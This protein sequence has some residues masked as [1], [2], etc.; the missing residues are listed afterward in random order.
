MAAPLEDLF[1]LYSE[2]GPSGFQPYV[3]RLGEN[4]ARLGTEATAIVFVV[5]LR[6]GGAMLA[7]PMNS[8]PQSVLETGMDADFTV[9]LGPSL[10]VEVTAAHFMEDSPLMDPP[11]IP[12]ETLQVLLADF[13]GSIGDH[14]SE[15]T[16]FFEMDD[17][18]PFRPGDSLVIPSPDDL[19]A[20]AHSW[21]LAK[22]DLPERLVFYSAAEEE[23]VPETPRGGLPPKGRKATTSPKEGVADK[24]KQKPTVA[25][26][27]EAVTSINLALPQL[28]EQLQI[29]ADR[30][31][32]ME[33]AMQQ[34]RPSALRRPLAES[35]M[36]GLSSPPPLSSFVKEMPPPR[37]LSGKKQPASQSAE[38]G[39][40]STA[41]KEEAVH[42]L[43]A[44]DQEST[45]AKAV[46]EQS[47]ALTQLVSQIASGS[48]DPLAD[49]GTSSSTVSSKGALGRA[50]LLQELAAH[51]GTF[52]TAVLQQMSRRMVP[53]SSS[54]L[55]PVQLMEKGVHASRYLERFGGYGRFKEYGHIIWQVAL[56]MDHLQTENVTA[57]QD[58]LA[59]LFVFLEQLVMDGGKMDVAILLALAEDPPAN[60]FSNRAFASSARNWAFAATADQ[61]WVTVALQYLKELDVIQT[62]RTEAT[63]EQ[64]SDLPTSEATGGPKKKKKGSG[65]GKRQAEEEVQN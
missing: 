54:D 46:L 38:G 55:T 14:L 49:M 47:R 45:L 16:D 44:E 13:N 36:L 15:L 20:A 34:G 1:P 3:L 2:T 9:L 62:R 50:K 65:K 22:E 41:E 40:L 5:L 56:V 39:K 35:A 27:S 53:G 51:K 17:L 63:K 30:T 24:R 43:M 8:I 32:A 48:N 29:L 25:S 33:M 59:L 7:L 57:A 60:L 28:T 64:K 10:A 52:F 26:L 4:G 12:G 19:V 21:T 23:L 58:A 11:T 42:E 6:D 31:S 61:R 37:G 18:L